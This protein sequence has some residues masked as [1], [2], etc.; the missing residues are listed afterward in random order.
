MNGTIP[1]KLKNNIKKNK[2]KNQ[3]KK[4]KCI[5]CTFAFI[6]DLTNKIIELV[7]YL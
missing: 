4:V 6:T 5:V 1:N 7:I 3:G 2:I